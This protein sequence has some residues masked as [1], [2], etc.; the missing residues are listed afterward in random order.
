MCVC[1]CVDHKKLK[2]RKINQ[3]KH[4]NRTNTIKKAV[5]VFSIAHLI[6]SDPCAHD[7]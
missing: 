5:N 7:Y 3:P 6:Q 4:L 2:K 1:K